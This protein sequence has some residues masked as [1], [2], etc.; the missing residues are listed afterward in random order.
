MKTTAH[1]H[2]AYAA[3]PCGGGHDG[4]ALID[5]DTD[6]VLLWRCGVTGQIFGPGQSHE[7]MTLP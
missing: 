4:D 5:D 6:K 3:C 1:W 2:E 7:E